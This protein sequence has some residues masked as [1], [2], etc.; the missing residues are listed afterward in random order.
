MDTLKKKMPQ[1]EKSETGNVQGKNE[2]TE[3]QQTLSWR[4][5][6][7]GPVVGIYMLGYMMSY[8]TITEYTNKVWRDKKLSDAKITTNL[9][10]GGGCAV[11]ESNLEV[12][13]L[14]EASS[15][16]SQYIVYYSL[17]QG[18]PA[19]VSNLILGSY[20]DAFGRKFL[21]AVGISGTTMRIILS[22][23]IIY[24]KMDI[25]FFL[26]ACILEGFTGQYVT[27]FQ[28]GLA[29]ISDVT[30]PGNQRTYGVAYIIFF[31]AFC[32][33]VAS[34]L[35]GYLSQEYSFYAPFFVAGVLLI[36][37]FIAMLILLPESLPPTKRLTNKS[38]STVLYNSFSFFI[39]N[40]FGN[41]KWKYRLIL[42]AHAFCDFSFLGR[43]GVETL[44]QLADPFCWSVEKVESNRIFFMNEV[45]KILSQVLITKG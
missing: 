26:G 37:T 33:G 21:L 30:K 45:N 23:C 42:L 31:L 35:A 3:D 6:L 4:R 5:F 16:A 14:K 36:L 22:F 7:I 34:L 38:L 28:V 29:Y 44:Y 41:N 18:V 32:S 9:T 2:L 39:S 19:V 43:I 40:D 27:T 25:L 8:Y 1:E 24:F 13:I 17:A 12:K 11:N 10:S 15:M 20:T